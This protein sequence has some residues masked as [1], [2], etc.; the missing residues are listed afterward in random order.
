[1]LMLRVKPSK[2]DGVQLVCSRTAR[3]ERDIKERN[4]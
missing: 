2:K 4:R 3:S 1:M